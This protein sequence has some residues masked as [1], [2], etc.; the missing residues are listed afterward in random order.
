[1]N[2]NPEVVAWDPV[3]DS[4]PAVV[5]SY[6]FPRPSYQ[7]DVVLAYVA[8]VGPACDGLC[9]KN[10]RGD[11]D[12]SPSGFHFILLQRGMGLI[13][14]LMARVRLHLLQALS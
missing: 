14:G 9:N 2:A 13:C 4:P 10:G 12:I 3:D 7:G 6:Y 5:F 8:T 1:M 11:P